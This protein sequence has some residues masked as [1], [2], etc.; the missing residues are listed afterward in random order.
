MFEYWTIISHRDLDF[1][2][3]SGKEV[4]GVQLFLSRRCSERGWHGY[5]VSKF[6]IREGSEVL[7]KPLPE[8]GTDIQIGF[9]RFGKISYLEVV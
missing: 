3:D 2:D 9:N 4:K 5:E 1:K 7:A 8:P 6:F